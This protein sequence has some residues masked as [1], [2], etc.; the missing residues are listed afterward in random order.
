MSE[1]E[2]KVTDDMVVSMAYVLEVDGEEIDRA[3]EDDPMLFLQGHGNIIPGLESELYDMGV[4]DSKEVTV[5]PAD[6]YG[7]LDP[8]NRDQI[9]RDILPPDY[10]PMIGDPLELRDTETGEVFQVY[11]ADLDD[12]NVIV[13]FNHPLA[14]ETLN[15]QVKIVDLRPA[16]SEELAH[17]HVHTHGHHH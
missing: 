5:Q 17:G 1:K 16:Q 8:E 13:D 11:V 14:G 12:E 3:D 7:E 2:P 9:P 4:G 10:E 15:F 6:A